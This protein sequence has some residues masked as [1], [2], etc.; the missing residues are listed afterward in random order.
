MQKGGNEINTC[1]GLGQLRMRNNIN[2][3]VVCSACQCEGAGHV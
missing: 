2:S 3:L 1:V